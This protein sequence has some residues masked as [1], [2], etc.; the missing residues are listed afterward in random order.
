MCRLRALMKIGM[1]DP[2]G[3]H[4]GRLGHWLTL[5]IR[6]SAGLGCHTHGAPGLG[7]AFSVVGILGRILMVLHGTGRGLTGRGEGVAAAS[8]ADG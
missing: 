4:R 8:P 5:Y 3:P 1:W 7:I 6:G 2:G